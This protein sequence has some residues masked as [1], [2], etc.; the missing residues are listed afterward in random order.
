M[1]RL[2]VA[3]SLALHKL[4]RSLRYRSRIIL[5][6][7]DTCVQKVIGYGEIVA[8]AEMLLQAFVLGDELVESRVCVEW[9]DGEEYPSLGCSADE[10]RSNLRCEMGVKVCCLSDV[11]DS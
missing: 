6:M 5:A 8:P 2:T 11:L 7:H 1:I 4:T 3:R 10:E 9:R